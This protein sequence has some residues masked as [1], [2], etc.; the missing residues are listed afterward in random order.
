MNHTRLNI[1]AIL[2][3]VFSFPSRAAQEAGGN[4]LASDAA[5]AYD[6]KDWVKSAKLYGELSQ[7]SQAPPRIWLRLESDYVRTQMYSAAQNNF[8]AFAGI[9]YRF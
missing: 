2:L 5:S 3:V 8:Q 7:S 6:A 9:S 1:A 4:T